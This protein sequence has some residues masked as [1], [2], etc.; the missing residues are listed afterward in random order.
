MKGKRPEHAGDSKDEDRYPPAEENSR[1]AEG[2][3]ATGQQP[4]EI[5]PHQDDGHG[6]QSEKLKLRGN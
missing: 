5:Q 1:L 4:G 6:R 3:P 2:F